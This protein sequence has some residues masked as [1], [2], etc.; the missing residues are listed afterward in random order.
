LK[1]VHSSHGDIAIDDNGYVVVAESKYDDKE[2]INISRFDLVEY[3]KAYPDEPMPD[4][5]DILDLAYWTDKGDY[6]PAEEDFRNDVKR[7]KF[8]II[9]ESEIKKT[10]DHWNDERLLRFHAW[11]TANPEIDFSDNELDPRF[12]TE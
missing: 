5:F 6:I 11:L 3:Q 4:E 12:Q 7:R 8:R 10:L 9:A 1:H 2:L